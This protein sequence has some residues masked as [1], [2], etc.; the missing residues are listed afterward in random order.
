[1]P[2]SVRYD[3]NLKPMEKIIYSEITALVNSKGYCYAT[4][5]YFANLYEVHKKTVAHWISNLTNLGYLKVEM[6]L[7]KGGK[8][9]EERRI[10]ILERRDKVE[11]VDDKNIDRDLVEREEKEFF[12]VENG[13]EKNKEKVEIIEEEIVEKKTEEEILE[14]GNKNIPRYEIIPEGMKKWGG[15]EQNDNHPH[16]EKVTGNNTSRIIKENNYYIYTY[17]G[18]ENLPV[19]R[20][21]LKKYSEL[22]LPSYEY[23]PEKKP[24]ES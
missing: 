5:S 14:G 8:E 13:K 23:P 16:H 6:I 20:E 4:N 7:K 24:M 10:Y 15:W 22:G 9:V 1:M 17:R 11:G 3:K 2:A 19:V 12:E 21:I 18:E